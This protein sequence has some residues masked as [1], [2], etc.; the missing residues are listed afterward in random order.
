MGA[1][2]I[3]PRAARHAVMAAY[4][5]IAGAAERS[6]SPTP[7]EGPVGQVRRWRQ[8]HGGM[9]IEK[10]A[11]RPVSQSDQAHASG[12]RLPSSACRGQLGPAPT[13]GLLFGPIAARDSS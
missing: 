5:Q 3:R 12:A 6:H 4:Y 8:A 7:M 1:D 10:K 2:P 13:A 9:Q 11:N